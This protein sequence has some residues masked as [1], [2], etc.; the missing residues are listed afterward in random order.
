MNFWI[1][2]AQEPLPQSIMAKHRRLWR[3]NTIAELL[4]NRGH[5]VTR[6]RSGYSHYEKRYLAEGSPAMNVEGCC[7][8][9]F[10]AGPPY[11]RHIGYKR[12]RH[13]RAIASKFS[14]FAALKDHRPDAIHVGNVP[15]ELCR[16][17]ATFGKAYRIPVVIDIRDLWPDIFLDLVPVS[18]A[19]LK[20]F[21]KRLL[22]P[23][24]RDA[25]YAMRHATAVTGITQPFV[26]WGLRLAG[27]AATEWDQVFHMSYPELPSVSQDTHGRELLQKLGLTADDF[28]CCYFGAIGHQS[29][30]DTLI[31]TARRIGKSSRIKLV[32]CG[33]GPKL[34]SLRAKAASSPCIRFPGWIDTEDIQSL[35]RVAT[36]G[37]IPFKESDNYV[38]N[39]PNKFSEYLSGG[40]VLACGLR[41]EMARLIELHECGFV[42]PSGNAATLARKL[43]ELSET[44]S[45]RIEGM[46][47]RSKALFRDQF[48]CR[49]VY[50][51]VCEYLEALAV[52]GLIR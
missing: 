26:D 8:F 5:R 46:R 9:Q 38:L 19:F 51:R 30:F 18:L 13:H 21:V 11:R 23:S 25:T 10:L 52:C 15:I 22:R 12:V 1:I 7:D 45:S 47:Q 39:M 32:I 17:V 28:I 50:A 49:I 16:A 35:M 3:S 2:H 31:E 33:E 14:E 40:L 36:V 4:V 29:D 24:Y 41:G 42:Y 20:P 37:L 48:D 44:A 6:W 27:R 43:I 34:D